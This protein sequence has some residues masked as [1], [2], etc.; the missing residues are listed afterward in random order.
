MRYL[1]HSKQSY[2]ISYTKQIC[3]WGFNYK[4]SKIWSLTVEQNKYYIHALT[5]TNFLI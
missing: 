1:T 3:N 2:L 4:D 5:F